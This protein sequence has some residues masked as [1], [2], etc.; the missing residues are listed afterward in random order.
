MA[1]W[2]DR[3]LAGASGKDLGSGFGIPEQVKGNPNG[4][5]TTYNS[6]KQN[7][8]PLNTINDKNPNG[9]PMQIGS[10]TVTGANAL[11]KTPNQIQ[12]EQNSDNG[13]FIANT[14]IPFY[15]KKTS[16]VQ[17]LP[18][19]TS[20]VPIGDTAQ[21]I[22]QNPLNNNTQKY[23]YNGPVNTIFG[24]ANFGNNNQPQG[25]QYNTDTGNLMGNYNF[26]QD[27]FNQDLRGTS[28]QDLGSLD[29][30]YRDRVADLGN[31]SFFDLLRGSA[32]ANQDRQMMRVSQQDFSNANK[33]AS[34]NLN[35]QNQL[36]LQDLISQRNTD[37]DSQRLAETTRNNN[38]ENQYKNDYM[39]QYLQPQLKASIENQ[40]SNQNIE[41]QKLGQGSQ[42]ANIEQELYN[43]HPSKMSSEQLQ[44]YKDSVLK[45]PSQSIIQATEMLQ[46]NIPGAKQMLEQEIN[47][48]AQEQALIDWNNK[49]TAYLSVYNPSAL[50]K[51][52]SNVETTDILTPDNENPGQFKV[53]SREQKT[54]GPQNNNSVAKPTND[55]K[56]Y[57]YGGVQIKT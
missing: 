19:Q 28:K 36:G 26:N 38:N 53:Q 20:S 44:S 18:T 12:A 54:K 35:Q 39:N 13:G 43:S 51:S 49:Q 33:Y 1:T 24:S 6:S 52:G 42:K 55:G 14:P 23:S 47:K 9:M 29:Q 5:F 32:L 17:T 22:Y 7:I 56:T 50:I 15:A 48:Q 46:Q 11:Y 25:N 57:S 4:D 41:R 21:Q 10:N 40:Q 31:G 27:K 45:N 3:M 2:Y 16:P 37:M 34:D 30:Q 8:V